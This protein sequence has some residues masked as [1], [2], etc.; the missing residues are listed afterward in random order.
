L[1][2][3]AVFSHRW[4]DLAAA[5]PDTP[6]SAV[7]NLSAVP[8]RARSLRVLIS[9]L[10]YPANPEP[11]IRALRRGGGRA[12]ILAPFS[13]AESDPDWSGN[14]EFVDSESGGRHDRR[15]DP[16]L[17]RRYTDAYRDHFGRW[18]AASVRAQAP[19]ARIASAPSF[20]AALR[21]EAI[22]AGVLQLG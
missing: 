18:K 8:L 14:Y 12:I 2:P 1:R 20:E 3:G 10:L 5:L 16:P 13:A 19:L 9:D 4:Q 17:L 11:V 7:P 15:V 22:P 21:F 6:A